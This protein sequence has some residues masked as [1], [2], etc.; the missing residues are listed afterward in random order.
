LSGV[1][2]QLP[3]VEI[4]RERERRERKERKG[5]RKIGKK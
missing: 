1:K 3:E 4:Q 2:L 5:D